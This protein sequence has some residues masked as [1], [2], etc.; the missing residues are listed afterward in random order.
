[1]PYRI[2]GGKGSRGRA[3]IIQHRLRT[4]ATSVSLINH[5]SAKPVEG[6]V[7]VPTTGMYDARAISSVAGSGGSIIYLANNSPDNFVMIDRMYTNTVISAAALPNTSTYIQILMR[8]AFTTGT[9]TIINADNTNQTI[10]NIQ[11][12][13]T[14]L[15]AAR[16][17]GGVELSRRYLN[18]SRTY[19]QEP[20]IQ[21]SDGIILGKGN[22]IEFF[23]A[24]L[25]STTTEVNMRFGVVS[26]DDI[27]L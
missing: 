18:I 20:I 16:T 10:I 6:E 26:K 24:T 8:S 1:M 15:N 25:T 9:G 11:P 19:F 2:E 23:V 27:G 21:K 7:L 3:Q 22:S 4:F 13:I 17:S 14:L 5:I 12:D